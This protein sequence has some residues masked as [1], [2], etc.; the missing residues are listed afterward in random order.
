MRQYNTSFDVY[1]VGDTMGFR[2]NGETYE[3]LRV[4]DIADERLYV[5]NE[6][7]RAVIEKATGNAIVFPRQ[8]CAACDSFYCNGHCPVRPRY[9]DYSGEWRNSIFLGGMYETADHSYV[10][11]Q[12]MTYA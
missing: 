1:K 8:P 3:G 12:E 2:V 7:V 5:E 6:T 9:E 11:S 10:V 4:Y